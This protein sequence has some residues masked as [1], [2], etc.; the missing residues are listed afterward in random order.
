MYLKGRIW[1]LKL[2][3]QINK[4]EIGK[5]AAVAAKAKKELDIAKFE[6]RRLSGVV[7]KR[8]RRRDRLEDL[9]SNRSDRPPPLESGCDNSWGPGPNPGT[10]CSCT[11]APWS[12]HAPSTR[13]SPRQ[14]DSMPPRYSGKEEQDEWLSAVYRRRRDPL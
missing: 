6:A 1:V 13:G 4:I 11:D 2:E 3:G 14:S 10:S 9:R 8:Q 12:G 7:T 5:S